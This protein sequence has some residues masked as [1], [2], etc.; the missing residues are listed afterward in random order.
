MAS[1]LHIRTDLENLVEDLDGGAAL[2]RLLETEKAEDAAELVHLMAG[3]ASD[4]TVCIENFMNQWDFTEDC[5]R[6][7]AKAE[8]AIQKVEA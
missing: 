5:R 2:G 3:V 8:K 4:L 6:A 1:L 7:A